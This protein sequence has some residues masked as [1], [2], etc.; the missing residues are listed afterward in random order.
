HPLTDKF[1][2]ADVIV[3]CGAPVY[4]HNGKH[5]SYTADWHNALWED[6]IFKLSGAKVILNLGAGAGQGSVDDLA[7]MLDDA[8]L[9][10]FA[11]AAGAACRVTTTRDP[12][13]SQFLHALEVGHA[14]LPCPAFH[15]AL[16]F[17]AGRQFQPRDVL[18]VN[19]MPLA[20]HFKLKPETN[21]A[22]WQQVIAETLPILR[23]DH[24]L[25]F[26]AHNPAEREFQESLCRGSE[27]V[28]YSD[29]YR[30]YLSIYARAKGIVSNRV[31]AAVVVAGFGRPAVLVGNDA[32]LGIATP[33]GI[34]AADS[35]VAD[36]GWIVRSINEQLNDAHNIFIQRRAL[37]SDS[38]RAYQIHLGEALNPL[39]AQSSRDTPAR[40]PCAA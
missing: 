3:Q 15:A 21:P 17:N 13:A 7:T 34:P 32:R 2:D 24:Q 20:G 31:H 10:A 28:F 4:W 36:A 38:A 22:R 26:V 14:L 30:D 16:R 29:D 33:I 39:D 40:L 35:S 19:L 8:T 18:A 23:R 6:R 1:A 9:C 12:L 37:Q 5:R 11:R 27:A 25:V